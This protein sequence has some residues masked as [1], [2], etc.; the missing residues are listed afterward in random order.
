MGNNLHLQSILFTI[1]L[2]LAYERYFLMLVLQMYL[3]YPSFP[4]WEISSFAIDDHE[5]AIKSLACRLNRHYFHVTIEISIN[6]ELS[7]NVKYLFSY[8]K[9]DAKSINSI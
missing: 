2:F 1:T 4:I 8:F 5:S 7:D 3:I 9:N 6:F